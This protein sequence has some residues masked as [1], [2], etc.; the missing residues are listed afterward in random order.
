MKEF[1]LN[2]W[3]KIKQPTGWKLAVSLTLSILIIAGTILAVIFMP[4]SFFNYVLYVLAFVS[5]IWLIYLTIYLTP[6]VKAM[7]KKIMSKNKYTNKFATSYSFRAFIFAIGSFLINAGYAVMMGVVA[8]IIKSAWYGTFAIYYLILSIMRGSILL[9]KKHKTKN[10]ERTF[11]AVAVSLL[12]LTIVAIVIVIITYN[13]ESL[14][15]FKGLMIYASAAYTFY[16]VCLSTYNIFKAK[17]Q[18]SLLVEAVKDISFVDA[19]VSIFVLQ[20]SMLQV[21]ANETIENSLMLNVLTGSLV[22][23]GIIA[24]AVMMILKYIKVVR[25]KKQV[26]PVETE[27]FEEDEIA[28]S[29]TAVKTLTDAEKTQ[30]TT[31]GE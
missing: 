16:R 3:N 6:I 4:D 29:T 1:F 8:I 25:I 30:Y 14:S 10:E 15:R 17:R 26:Q 20:V 31:F 27:K 12:I 5:L 19:I 24:V 13:G 28:K 2:V 21:F 18:E 7:Y 11:L 23:V 22:C 9:S